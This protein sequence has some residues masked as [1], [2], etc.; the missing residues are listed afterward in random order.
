MS[1]PSCICQP[2]V[3]TQPNVPVIHGLPTVPTKNFS[4]P[5]GSKMK[6]LPVGKWKDCARAE[7]AVRK[8]NSA[9][10][11]KLTIALFDLLHEVV[12]PAHDAIR[13][14]A[15]GVR[16]K[17]QHALAHPAGKF[18]RRQP[19]RFAEIADDRRALFAR[20]HR[21]LIEQPRA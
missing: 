2:S 3:R 21:V 12:Q 17:Y 4:S 7:S 5:P 9:V 16:S 1:R 10:L 15:R 13:L 20:G 6:R 18:R 14:R 19:A 8:K 11:T